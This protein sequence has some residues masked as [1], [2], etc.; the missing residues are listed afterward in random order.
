M[1]IYVVLLRVD[2][3]KGF[4]QKAILCCSVICVSPP[5]SFR[6]FTLYF[7]AKLLSE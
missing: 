6:C 7:T 5:G 4:I 2:V 1:F 3:L